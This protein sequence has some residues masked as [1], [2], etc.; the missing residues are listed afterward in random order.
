MNRYYLDG[1]DNITLNHPHIPDANNS[2]YD[3][4]EETVFHLLN[5]IETKKATNQEDYPAWVSK[6][7]S[8]SLYKPIHD[9]ICAIL[10][11]GKFPKIWEKAQVC[12][13][14]KRKSPAVYKDMHPISVLY[15][16]S[17]IAEKTIH[18]SLQ[19]QLPTF[20]SQFAYTKD[21]ET[22]Y[23]LV[24]LCDEK[25]LNLAIKDTIATQVSMLPIT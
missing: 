3:V 21:L 2:K 18:T 15:H 5:K 4:P 14:P 6:N 13:I 22:V 10:T 7:N 9:I 17:K 23:A 12:L 24:G 20:D 25:T 11:T 1:H 19:K 8:A 16:F